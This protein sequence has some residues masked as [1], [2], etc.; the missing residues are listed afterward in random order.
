[1]LHLIAAAWVFVAVLAAAAEATSPAGTVIGAV[2][3]LLLYGV[4][5]LSIVLYLGATPHRRRARLAREAQ[6]QSA[7]APERDGSHHASAGTTPD[8]AAVGEEARITE[9]APM[10]TAGARQ[11]EQS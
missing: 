8:F 6:A 9:G 5:P 4:L 7:A 11:P 1:M 3:T 10:P 2:F